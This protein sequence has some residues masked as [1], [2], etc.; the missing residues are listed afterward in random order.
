MPKRGIML[1]LDEQ[2]IEKLKRLGINMSQLAGSV[3]EHVIQEEEFHP[4]VVDL[5]LLNWDIQS[6]RDRKDQRLKEIASIEGMIKK[7][8]AERAKLM[9]SLSSIRSDTRVAKAFERLSVLAKLYTTDEVLE[10]CDEIRKDFA[11]CG[12]D[13]SD[14]AIRAFV[15]RLRST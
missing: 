5:M 11:A 12:L 1:Y 13:F 9:E 14:D 2:L 4:I 8:E 15:E 6:L 3:F 7:L 10:H